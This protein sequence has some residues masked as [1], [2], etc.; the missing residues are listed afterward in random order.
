MDLIKIEDVFDGHVHLRMGHLLQSVVNHTAS[1]CSAAL[2]MP[3]T[4]P[5]IST[6]NDARQYRD[7]IKRAVEY[8]NQPFAP[9][10][11][12]KV[13]DRTTPEMIRNAKKAGVSAGKTYPVSVTTGSQDG[14]SD[15]RKLFPVFSAM[16]ANNMPLS[17]HGE[18]PGSPW[19][20]SEVDFLPILDMISRK[21]PELRIVMEHVS[22][23]ESVEFVK[24]RPN[25]WG[26]ITAHHMYYTEKNV[27]ARDRET[28]INP[29][30][31]CKPVCGNVEDKKALIAAA[32]S[33]NRKFFYG[34]DSAPHWESNKLGEK[35][36]F[37]IFAA[38]TALQIVVETFVNQGA[39]DKLQGFLSDFGLGFYRAHLS[40][41]KVARFFRTEWKV[42]ERYGNVVPLAAG[43][44]LE[45]QIQN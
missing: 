9:L 40:E 31:L 23:T 20:T 34:S 13:T 21:F 1:H 22:R 45:W 18:L 32:I 33:G 37:G 8:Q 14:V 41:N 17:M 11:T 12:I 19:W 36:A 30:R 2:I 24:S 35:P 15:F 27:Y 4:D 10:M 28:I 42:P 5:P 39:S 25:V 7:T 26:T 29:H 6:A 38:P 16:Q 43:R 3:N 44:T